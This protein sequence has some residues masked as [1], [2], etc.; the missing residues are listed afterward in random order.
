MVL[1]KSVIWSLF[2]HCHSITEVTLNLNNSF[3]VK[4]EF[5]T[6]D[7][8]EYVKQQW[9]P[10]PHLSLI[11]IVIAGHRDHKRRAGGTRERNVS[12]ESVP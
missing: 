10:G 12:L 2:F 11:I 5:I 9:Y 3:T 4:S 8:I 7:L 1:K 6:F